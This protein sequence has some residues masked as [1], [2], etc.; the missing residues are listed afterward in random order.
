MKLV[1]RSFETGWIQSA[2]FMKSQRYSKCPQVIPEYM[3]HVRAI[4]NLNVIEA[5]SVIYLN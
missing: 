3:Y 4:L 5:N 2:T 1:A